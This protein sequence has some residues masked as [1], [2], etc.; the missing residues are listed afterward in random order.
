MFMFKQLILF[1]DETGKDVITYEEFYIEIQNNKF[2]CRN[3]VKTSFHV[4]DNSLEL[5]LS[6]DKSESN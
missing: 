6:W 1:V 2:K 4:A 5:D 3:N